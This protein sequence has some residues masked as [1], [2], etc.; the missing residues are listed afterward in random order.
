MNLIVHLVVVI[1]FPEEYTKHMHNIITII[2]Q[3]VFLWRLPEKLRDSSS[4]QPHLNITIVKPT[5]TV[6]GIFWEKCQYLGWWCTGSFTDSKI[7]GANMGP[8]GDLS[9]PGGPHVG[10][11]NLAI[12]MGSPGHQAQWHWICRID[13]S[14]S[15]PTKNFKNLR[16]VRAFIN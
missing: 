7:H 12:R 1:W 3:N 13:R 14:L 6:T 15:C 2:S 4:W 16:H 8:I 9:A 10:P 5:G 11:I